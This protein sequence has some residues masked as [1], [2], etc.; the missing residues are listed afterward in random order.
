MPT[1]YSFFVK[2]A[3]KKQRGAACPLTGPRSAMDN[4]SGQIKNLIDQLD[5]QSLC[6]TTRQLRSCP[7]VVLPRLE[8]LDMA[9][10]AWRSSLRISLELASQ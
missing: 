6:I 2:K 9:S 4:H 7:E 5:S 8:D 3:K 1:F 10:K